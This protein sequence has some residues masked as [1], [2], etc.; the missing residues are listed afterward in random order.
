MPATVGVDVDAVLG[1]RVFM[2]LHSDV[3]G[4]GLGAWAVPWG[5]FFL[6]AVFL[7]FWVDLGSP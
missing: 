1:L 4:V 3:V 5:C 6:L 7:A 2:W